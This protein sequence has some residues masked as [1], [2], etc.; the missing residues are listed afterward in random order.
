L[1]GPEEPLL[2]SPEVT[3]CVAFIGRNLGKGIVKV[4]TAFFIL[5]EEDRADNAYLVTAKH[6]ID[7]TIEYSSDQIVYI[8]LNYRDGTRRTVM[9]P[10]SEWCAHPNNNDID[11][12]LIPWKMAKDLDHSCIPIEPHPEAKGKRYEVGIG[13]DIFIPG[14]FLRHSGKKKN[15]PILRTGTI[16]ALPDEPVQLYSDG[17]TV[18]QAY[19][20]EAHSTGGLSG[21]P[22]LAC[23]MEIEFKPS[24]EHRKEP[25]LRTAH[26][27]IG[28]VSAHWQ[29]DEDPKEGKDT[30]SSINSGIA[31]V[32]PKESVL[33]VL[34]H[35]RLVEMREQEKRR[36]ANAA[37]PTLDDAQKQIR[38]NRDI[39]IPPIGRKDFFTDLTKVTQRQKK[40]EH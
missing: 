16:A 39:A 37:A 13:T 26:I 27:W 33:E 25:R 5:F 34:Q 7:N 12:A 8:E 1:A 19:L 23:P 11:V 17:R 29:F 4:G 40:K 28:M 35:P 24:D 6:L 18:P 3:R 20:V 22:V 9:T 31:V 10:P 2:L 15:I 38:K 21:S 32:T 14:L 36:R 30:E